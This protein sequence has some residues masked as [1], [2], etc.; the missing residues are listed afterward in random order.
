[1]RIELNRMII[2]C[3]PSQ[4]D[5]QSLYSLIKSALGVY[6]SC[7]YIHIYPRA[8]AQSLTLSLLHCMGLDSDLPCPFLFFTLRPVPSAPDRLRRW[9]GSLRDTTA[10]F[11]VWG[12][13]DRTWCWCR[14][15]SK[16]L[17]YWISAAPST[18][19]RSCLPQLASGNYAPIDHFWRRCGH[20][21]NA[22][23]RC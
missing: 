11:S 6:T 19:T 23:G 17:A 9:D 4:L 1:M 22:G 10:T 21:W 15:L 20:V 18:L 5:H 13:C 2:S 16:G 12:K 7:L 8:G 3:K 14:T